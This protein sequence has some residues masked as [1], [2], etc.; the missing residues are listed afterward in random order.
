[1]PEFKK[2]S[3]KSLDEPPG[4]DKFVSGVAQTPAQPPAP[5]PP[6]LHV[7]SDQ[8]P[9][10]PSPA[11]QSPM[12]ES[13]P[14]APRQKRTPSPR[15]APFNIRLSA[16]AKEALELLAAAD[17]RSQNQIL[18]RMLEPLLIEAAAKLRR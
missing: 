6:A 4:F 18:T 3:R 8:S 7:V 1:M 15:K 2:P 13:L 12:A 5:P 9:A 11:T 10:G 17:S 14:A 16:Q